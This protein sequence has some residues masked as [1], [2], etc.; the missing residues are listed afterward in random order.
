MSESDGMDD[1]LDGGLRQSLMIAS[2][3]AATLARRRHESKRQQEH[4]VAQ[5]A[6]E[7]HEAQA[8]LTDYGSA[9]RQQAFAASLATTGANET[10]VRGRAAAERSEGTHPSAAVTM[11][12]GAVKANPNW[13]SSRF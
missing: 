5:A 10:Q 7:A 3:I 11:G 12:K 9:E 4:Q 2:R 8:L 6:H 13:G 1:V